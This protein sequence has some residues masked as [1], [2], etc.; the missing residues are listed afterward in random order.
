VAEDETLAGVRRLADG[1]ASPDERRRAVRALV[2]LAAREAGQSTD[3]GARSGT[4]IAAR[5]YDAATSAVLARV[6]AAGREIDRE[7]EEAESLAA[8]LLALP[9][10]QQTLVAVNHRRYQTW[11]VAERVREESFRVGRESP[12]RAVHLARLALLLAERVDPAPAS[13]RLRHDLE[14]AAWGQLGNALRLRGE[15]PEAEASFARARERVEQG[16]GDPL[17]EAGLLS[18]CAALRNDQSRFREAE[19]LARRA[20]AL[21]GKVGDRHQQGRAL[22]T[23][24]NALGCDGRL[25]EALVALGRARSL[26]DAERDPRMA[27]G[28]VHNAVIYLVEAE[29]F[30]EAKRLLATDVEE[31]DRVGLSPLDRL[32]LLWV[33]GRISLGLGDIAAAEPILRQAAEGLVERGYGLEG[34]TA[35][36]DL[37]VCFVEQRRWAEVRELAARLYPV[38]AAQEV[39]SE[40]L[41][42]LTV[43]RDAALAGTA[44]VAVVREVLAFLHRLDRDPTARFRPAGPSA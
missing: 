9:E 40:A 32:R 37:A 19:V 28:A 39:E 3:G 4:E 1:S 35:A 42:A 44:E 7:R 38:F 5:D 22:F 36:L 41:V 13:E 16:S 15:L 8:E 29:R 31:A 10:G 24:A 26:L 21:F 43:L 34:A 17:V 20:Y 12:V 23:L 27:W 14:A 30:D 33:E 11:S 18:L 2:R 6:Q 25:D